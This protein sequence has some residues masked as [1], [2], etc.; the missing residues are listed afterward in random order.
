[1]ITSAQFSMGHLYLFP[2][3]LLYFL[4]FDPEQMQCTP[5]GELGMFNIP[6]AFSPLAQLL[7]F[8][9]EGP[10]E[11]RSHNDGFGAMASPHLL[12]SP[13]FLT[14]LLIFFP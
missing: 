2:F 8:L 9:L 7:S 5:A 3:L 11:Q 12:C 1:M 10:L 14:H 4:H 13:T 6:L